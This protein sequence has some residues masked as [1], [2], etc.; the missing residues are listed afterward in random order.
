M[1]V[2]T[3][4]QARFEAMSNDMRHKMQLHMRSLLD[5]ETAFTQER[6]TMQEVAMNCA[7]KEFAAINTKADEGRQAY[8]ATREEI[9]KSHA[10][11]MQRS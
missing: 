10:M 2:E 11:R 3:M 6:A 9:R 1:C 4:F 8:D 7:A 5:P